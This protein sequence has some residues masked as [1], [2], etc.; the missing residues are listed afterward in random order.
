MKKIG[1]LLAFFAVYT[2][3]FGLTTVTFTNQ[4]DM[5][6]YSFV[7]GEDYNIMLK[8]DTTL[9]E[10]SQIANMQALLTI[11]GTLDLSIEHTLLTSLDGVQ[12]SS[13][14]SF[15]MEGNRLWDTLYI[16]DYVEYLYGF[17]CERTLLKRIHG[18]EKV[19]L[20]NRV[21][22]NDNDRLQDVYLGL[23]LLDSTTISLQLEVRLNDS[24]KTFY[25]GNP[26]RQLAVLSFFENRQLKHVHIETVRE[27]VS[28]ISESQGGFVFNVDLDSIS[29]FAGLDSVHSMF[30]KQNYLLENACVLQ[31]GIDSYLVAYPQLQHFF[32][33]QSNGSNLQSLNDLLTEDCSWLPNGIKEPTWSKLEI[34]PNPAH[35]EVYV[36]PSAQLTSYFIY[37]ISGKLVSQGTVTSSGRIALETISNGMYVLM[38]GNKRSKLI[39]Q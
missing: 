27:K 7:A 37:D 28:S 26:N 13:A 24:L 3:T 21:Y 2:A 29:G 15:Y 4:A 20:L 34:Y 17:T 30:I 23:Q 36:I 19:K 10:S 14:L 38:V 22:L 16:P 35:N 9:S 6:A 12:N 33:I 1:L 11:T 31:K 39:V 18:A 25:W 5:D 32:I 8:N